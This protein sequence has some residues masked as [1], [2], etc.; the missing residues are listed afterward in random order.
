MHSYKE[1]P[2]LQD[3]IQNNDVIMI[4]AGHTHYN[5]V[6]NDGHT[7]YAA[8]RS[9]GQISE[10]PVGFSIVNIDDGVVSWKF[11]PLGDWPFV[12]IT[13]PSD[14]RLLIDRKQAVH[15]TSSIHAKV[16]GDKEVESATFEIDG[17]SPLMLTQIGNTRIWGGAFDS[18]TIPDGD[19]N[20]VVRVRDA[21][22]KTATDTVTF[23]VNQTGDLEVGERSFGPTGNSIGVYRDKGLLG[24]QAHPG[25]GRFW[26]LVDWLRAML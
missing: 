22:G 14:A 19:H 26:R 25:P 11:K 24:T 10:G 7:I 21:T 12:M 16:W 15:G 23:V 5:S 18:T 3:L 1:A 8:T 6:A 13:T 20:V 9:T 4:D 17:G 2:A